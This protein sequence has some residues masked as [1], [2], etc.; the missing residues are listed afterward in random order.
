MA[1]NSFYYVG[2]LPALPANIRQGWSSNWQW[3]MAINSFHTMV[4]RK[5]R[6]YWHGTISLISFIYHEALQHVACYEECVCCAWQNVLMQPTGY[7][8]LVFIPTL[9][10]TLLLLLKG[11]KLPL[12]LSKGFWNNWINCWKVKSALNAIFQLNVGNKAF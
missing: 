12:W 2:R 6:D 8:I 7:S 9:G 11:C 3:Q 1:A 5:E 4:P 10:A